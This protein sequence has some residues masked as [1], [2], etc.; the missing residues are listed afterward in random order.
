MEGEEEARLLP[1]GHR[2][3]KRRAWE[4]VHPR[5]RLHLVL[6]EAVEE[7]EGEEEG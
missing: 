2:G 4:E 1:I 3:A 6:G 5:S 7:G